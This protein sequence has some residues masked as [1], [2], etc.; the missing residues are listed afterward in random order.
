MEFINL[1]PLGVNTKCPILDRYSPISY[2]IAQYVHFDLS[3]HSGLET[4]NRLALER[5]HI[6]Q[7]VSLFRELA[8]E[9][10]RC[11]IKRRRFLEMSMGPVGEHHFNVA[12]PF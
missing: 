7:G 12:H 9:C 5:V 3:G 11:K 8:T 4:C 10:I 6:I 2:S 1:E